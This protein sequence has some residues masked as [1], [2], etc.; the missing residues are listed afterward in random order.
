MQYHLS[1]DSGLTPGVTTRAPRLRGC[2]G[3]WRISHGITNKTTAESRHIRR[4]RV[5][6]VDSKNSWF[7]NPWLA[8]KKTLTCEVDEVGYG[9]R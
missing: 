7:E 1:G 6:D 8:E 4:E 2:G 9:A 5:E 3:A